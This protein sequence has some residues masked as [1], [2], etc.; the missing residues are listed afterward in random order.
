MSRIRIGLLVVLVGVVVLLPSYRAQAVDA[1]AENVALGLQSV[2]PVLDGVAALEVMQADLPLTDLAMAEALSL[3]SLFTA[4]LGTPLQQPF[5][6]LAALE[7]AIEGA[8]TTVE[9]V[10]L[11]FENVVVA[12]D[13]HNPAQVNVLFEVQATHQVV[14]PLTAVLT[15]TNTILTGGEVPLTVSLA[16]S[17]AFQLDTLLI[18]SDP[19]AAFYL[20]NT[21][22]IVLRVA[23]EEGIE[24]FA[25]RLGI[26]AVEASG[27]ALFD[28]VNEVAWV[29][30]DGNGRLTQDEWQNTA[31]ADLVV[32][33]FVDGAGDEV[34]VTLNV[35]AAPLGGQ[36]FPAAPGAT[37]VW[38][39]VDINSGLGEPTISWQNGLDGFANLTAD[40]LLTGI[41]QT[42]TGL[43]T[44]QSIGDMTLPL[45]D[46]KVSDALFLGQPLGD[47]VEQQGL[48]DITCG[49]EPGTSER[50]PFGD[51]HNVEAGQMVYCRAYTLEEATAVTWR[52]T[53]ETP[54]TNATHTAT[55]GTTP[56]A[57]IFFV[58]P[59][60]GKPNI[61][62]TL[63]LPSFGVRT[64]LPRFDTVQELFEQLLTLGN[65]DEMSFEDV[66]FDPNTYALTYHLHKTLDPVVQTAPLNVG[67]QLQQSTGLA[68][69]SGV[70][71]AAAEFRMHEAAFDIVLGAVLAPGV[72]AVGDRFFLSTQA[73]VPVLQANVEVTATL[74]LA[75]KIGF[76]EVS[77]TGD[78]SQNSS[79]D[80]AFELGPTDPETPMLAVAVTTGS[81]AVPGTSIVLPSAVGM[82]DFLADVGAKIA[83]DCNVSLS[84]GL[85][86]V[87]QMSGVTSATGGVHVVWAD[88]FEPGGCVPN[89]DTL[90]A[91]TTANFEAQLQSF[92][93]SPS[94]YGHYSGGA[95]SGDTLT[96]NG[97]AVDFTA[98]GRDLR[99]VQLLNK[100]D[101]SSCM[102][103]SLT[104]QSLTCQSG[105]QGGERNYWQAGDRYEVAGNPFA[106]LNAILDNI[107]TVVTVLDDV[108]GGNVGGILDE[109][110]PLLPVSPNDFL[111]HFRDIQNALDEVR[112]G[113]AEATI[114]CGPINVG[115]IGG[116]FDVDGDGDIDGDDDGL[117]NGMSI[118]DGLI[119]DEVLVGLA[120][121]NGRVDLNRDGTAN[122]TA[123][124][125]A[126]DPFAVLPGTKVYC[127]AKADG[128][129]ISNVS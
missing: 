71:N 63:E 48:A 36:A 37:I 35:A 14:A 70:G 9:G 1:Q 92:D 124:A 82:S 66:A 15:E 88:V 83:V 87:A 7:A 28:L 22:V 5:E 111:T 125:P 112:M 119:T 57:D 25:T 77:V 41:A 85:S 39:M 51:I 44:A 56:T 89:V 45:I 69:L 117:V 129:Q 128:N 106:L 17:F 121:I 47:F 103:T 11:T 54:I 34:A 97:G 109:P 24:P 79:S 102:I 53:P 40:A 116:A 42:A 98:V 10:A 110:L 21:P 101:G 96:D 123:A 99:G 113:G 30:P 104:S 20:T 3:S 61:E 84:A 118:S 72:E 8:D 18:D 4:G 49:T 95:T 62:L 50:P 29:D 80:K 100:T 105:L 86:A 32:A 19:A 74:Q 64:I 43:L 91:D 126:G 55:A 122:D 127:S 93:L 16:T 58:A 31:L 59:T 90:M 23:G 46:A 114:T 60:D 26:M 12:A 120:V 67:S 65:F 27:T 33:G 13:V 108:T 68:G 75:G 52:V 78:A 76:V 6:T 115:V 2:L 81:Y 38:Q 107:E 73:G 94:L